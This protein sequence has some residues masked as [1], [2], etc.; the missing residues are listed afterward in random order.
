MHAHKAIQTDPIWWT[1]KAFLAKQRTVNRQNNPSDP[2]KK[3][4]I[5]HKTGTFA[6]RPV[7]LPIDARKKRPV[8]SHLKSTLLG[9][10]SLHKPEFCSISI[11]FCCLSYL[12]LCN[13]YLHLIRI[14]I[15][16]IHVWGII[17]D[18]RATRSELTVENF[19]PQSYAEF[20]TKQYVE[21]I[22]YFYCGLCKKGFIYHTIDML[23]LYSLGQVWCF[24]AGYFL[25]V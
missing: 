3:T 24:L 17:R 10:S 12:K 19:F 14:T 15:W 23:V 25:N 9:S 20:L 4:I 13:S 6:E 22:D 16:C 8:F 2:L 7:V 21:S 5:R 11:Q 18:L 1:T